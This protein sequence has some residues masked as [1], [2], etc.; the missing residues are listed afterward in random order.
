MYFKPNFFRFL[1]KEWNVNLRI[2]ND[3][4]RTN[5][6]VES[7]NNALAKSLGKKDP[8]IWE[9][10]E[11][12][13]Y[14]D[15]SALLKINHHERGDTLKQSKVYKDINEQL[16]NLVNNYESQGRNDRMMFLR[17]VSRKLKKVEVVEVEN[18]QPID[19]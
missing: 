13:Q 11:A 14:E 9:L 7:L 18:M 12:F 15:G 2:K 10:I 4:P 5:N 19:E 17:M 16:Q 6:P 8:I 3:L 1:I